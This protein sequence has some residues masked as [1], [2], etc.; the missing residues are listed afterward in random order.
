[1]SKE[2][3]L[4]T[5]TGSCYHKIEKEGR[6]QTGCNTHI[7]KKTSELTRDVAESHDYDPCG[8]NRCFGDE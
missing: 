3:V 1:M 5:K 2:K 8:D 6:G 4:V 7:S